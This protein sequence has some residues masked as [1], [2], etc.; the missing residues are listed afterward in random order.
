MPCRCERLPLLQQLQQLRTLF[1]AL[2]LLTFQLV[3]SSSLSS[4]SADTE[5]IALITDDFNAIFIFM[6][7]FMMKCNQ[8]YRLTAATFS[9]SLIVISPLVITI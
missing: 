8:S 6:Y 3:S 5:S 2:S 1:S 9:A 7:I 4:A